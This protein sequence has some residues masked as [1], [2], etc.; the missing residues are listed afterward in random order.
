M[1]GVDCWDGGRGGDRGEKSGGG[2]E[3]GRR[4]ME[5]RWGA[6]CCGGSARGAGGRHAGVG[7]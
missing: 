5:G 6:V 7:L 4:A 3:R 2:E 1:E